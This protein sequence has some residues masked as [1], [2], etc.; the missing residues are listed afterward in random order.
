VLFGRDSADEGRMRGRNFT[1]GE[2]R[3]LGPMHLQQ[4]QQDIHTFFDSAFEECGSISRSV[5]EDR[6]VV[7]LFDVHTES[8]GNHKVVL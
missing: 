3:G 1:K 5:S 7:I 4:G 6:C 8:V 2:E